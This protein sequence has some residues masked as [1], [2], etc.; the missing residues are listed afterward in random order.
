VLAG[1]AGDRLDGG[2]GDDVIS[3]MAGADTLLGGPGDDFLED[4]IPESP[5]VADTL[6]CGPGVDEPRSE[7]GLD[8]LAGCKQP[9]N[10]WSV[11]SSSS[12]IK[13]RF[14][15]FRDGTTKFTR[16]ASV[17]HRKIPT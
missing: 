6:D 2:D 9:P 8:V 15:R 11:W 16:S 5:P 4:M 13:Y 12:I 14:R 1:T 17:G 3:G 10:E 7:L